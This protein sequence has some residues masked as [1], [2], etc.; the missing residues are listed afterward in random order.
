MSE[1]LYPSRGKVAIQRENT[2]GQ[3]TTEHGIIYNEKQKDIFF[4]GKVLSVGHP[5]VLPNGNVL[6]HEF[7]EGDI[8]VY[9][10]RGV[11]EFRGID[12]VDFEH[13]IGVVSESE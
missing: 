9:N 12:I 1:T 5:K 13:V 8:V 4:R 2:G 6:P 10:M 3:K 7:K 11:N